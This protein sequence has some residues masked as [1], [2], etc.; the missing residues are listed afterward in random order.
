MDNTHYTFRYLE[1]DPHDQARI[2]VRIKPGLQ[3][4]W[5]WNKP[6]RM[7]DIVSSRYKVFWKKNN[8]NEKH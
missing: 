1:D 7:S 3:F 8:N 2:K 4:S 5:N 6:G